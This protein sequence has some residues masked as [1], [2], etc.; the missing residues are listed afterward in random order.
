MTRGERRTFQTNSCKCRDGQKRSWRTEK[1]SLYCEP[2]G[3][4]W[5]AEGRIFL[6][7]DGCGKL[8]FSLMC[9]EPIFYDY[10]SK[11]IVAFSLHSRGTGVVGTMEISK[12]Q[13]GTEVGQRRRPYFE[14]LL[15]MMQSFQRIVV[16]HFAVVHGNNLGVHMRT[17]QDPS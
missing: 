4:V 6:R 8:P 11:D 7:S 9:W 13:V 2:V 15:K 17:Y 10:K 1:M 5:S 12:W 14:N 16:C 3:T